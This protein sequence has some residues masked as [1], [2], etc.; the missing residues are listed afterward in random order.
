MKILVLSDIKK[1][2]GYEQLLLKYKP[3]VT[4]LAGDL[5]WDGCAASWTEDWTEALESMPKFR[6]AKKQLMEQFGVTVTSDVFHQTPFS[7]PSKRYSA[8]HSQ[9]HELNQLFRETSFRQIRKRMHVDRFYNFL[10]HAGARSKVLVV[11][12]NHDSDFAEDY[13]PEKINNIRGCREISG[14]RCTVNGVSFLGVGFDDSHSSRS[15][16]ELLR[17]FGKRVEVIISHCEQRH[18]P[19]LSELSPKL[20]IRGHWGLGRYLVNGVLTVMTSN[21]EYT[22]ITYRSNS[23]PRIKQFW[24]SGKPV[25]R[26]RESC[27]S[28]NRLYS[29]LRPYALDN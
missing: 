23:I 1:W 16:T 19:V 26:N 21:A 15:L 18:L 4:V 25:E 8:Y 27:P 20:I 9:L 29:W 12:G 11:K 17:K 5:T 24:R 28:G 14:K 22:T 13:S 10:R 3:A 6:K 7:F 2:D